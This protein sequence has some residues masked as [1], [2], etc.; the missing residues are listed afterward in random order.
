MGVCCL[1]LLW[2]PLNRSLS[3]GSVME[4]DQTF[5][6]DSLNQWHSLLPYLE[7]L[8]DSADQIDPE[9]LEDKTSWTP[10]NTHQ[11]VRYWKGD[12]WLRLMI[13][14]QE[15]SP[16]E[17]ALLF[18]N[19]Y[20]DLYFRNNSN[21]WV[22]S[23]AGKNRALSVW[24]SQQHSP[25]FRSPYTFQLELP[26][27]KTRTYYIK[28][29]TIDQNAFLQP[30]ISNRVFFLEE[31]VSTFKRTLSTQAIFHGV[32]WVM[33]L[34]HLFTF[35]MYKDKAYLFYA[36][37]ILSL[38]FVLIYLF[39]F[40][41]FLPLAEVPRFWRLFSN[42]P[43]YGFG[44]FYC[45]FLLRFLHENHWKPRLKKLIQ[46]YIY[47]ELGVGTVSTLLL[48]V[49]PISAFP[50]IY[51]NLILLPI[52]LLGIGGLIFISIQYLRSEKGLARF[53]AFNNFF[54]IGGLLVSTIIGYASLS[55]FAD[56]RI[57][58]MWSIIFLEVTIIL[59]L[60]SFSLSL[61]YKGLETERERVKLKE[62]DEFKSRFFANISHEFRTP[63]TLI[64]GPVQNLL[65]TFN[66]Q[67]DRRQLKMVERNAKRLL[68]LINQI[69]D[70]SKLEAGRMKLTPSSFD[71]IHISKAM[72]HS[73]QSAAREKKV[74]LVF[75]SPVNELQV[76]LDQDK[77]EQIL[78]NLISNALK[79][80]SEGGKIELS[81]QTEKVRSKVFVK[82][83]VKDEG[84]GI[85]EGELPHIFKRFYQ[86][87]HKGFT[88]NQSSSGIGLALT[89]EL[90]EIQKGDINVDST[91]GKGTVFSFQL[92]LKIAHSAAQAKLDQKNALSVVPDG[93]SAVQTPEEG[94]G[95][96]NEAPLV[97]II[98]D[99]PEIRLYLKSCLDKDYQLIE[100]ANGQTGIEMAIQHIPDLIIT[101]VMMPEKD[102]FEV[103]QVI[104]NNEKTSHIP[105][106]ILT[107]KSSRESK[108]TGL[109]TS[110]DDYLTK[111][112]DAEEL[113]LRIKNLLQNREKW[114]ARFKESLRPDSP[115]LDVPSQEEKFIKKAVEVVELN[116]SNEDF[117]VEKM[118][119]A[120]LL[121][122]T[123]LFRKLKAITG[124]SPSKFIRSI[125]LK[126]A[127][128][129]LKRRSATV[130]EI[131][132]SVGFSST[133]YFNRCFKEEY[134]LTPGE[135]M[136]KKGS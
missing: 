93:L 31:S 5:L 69:L 72:L 38:S 87:D 78:I 100:S 103:T 79:Y 80:S 1:M 114:V 77:I 33:S 110:A 84:V 73:F 66:N 126:H 20:I 53:V 2:L 71:Y 7:I 117:S 11:Q 105:I 45:L 55:L 85:P 91:P 119:R 99:N 127:Y 9:K 86:A 59:Q 21:Q 136:E 108:I 106:I 88:T 17:L 76:I 8:Q 60:I 19:D 10:A 22:H 115:Y 50:S 133:T 52:A 112:F 24:D 113:L 123:Q 109:Q 51:K 54:M 90:I 3:Q 128:Q 118:G 37:Y 46:Y 124:Q 18:H 75:K 96:S 63:L 13:N 130:G 61:G 92:P 27:Q 4:I 57:T 67:A 23:S 28:I 35:F 81:V 125:R 14:N 44:I 104:K 48:I 120:L 15:E 132:F 42:I 97:H 94:S 107:G 39:E 129:L 30:F 83:S 32:L 34:F 68:R 64:L 41:I 29:G 47:L 58:Q 70:L 25:P 6:Q 65:A 43:L 74:D 116:L 89:K 98:E 135:V 16:V 12:L 82:T 49:L 40:D 122:R 56:Y 111:P 134:G 36:L 101:D 95:A 26:G 62:L 121:D 102:G 131:A